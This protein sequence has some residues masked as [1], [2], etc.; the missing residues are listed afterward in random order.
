MRIS[1][2]FSCD[3]GFGYASAGIRSQSNVMATLHDH[4][5]LLF[6]C[7]PKLNEGWGWP[8]ITHNVTSFFFFFFFLSV[9]RP[10]TRSKKKNC[11]TKRTRM[12]L[13]CSP[14]LRGP[15][16]FAPDMARSRGYRGV[17]GSSIQS[18]PGERVRAAQE[19]QG[20]SKPS[21]FPEHSGRPVEKKCG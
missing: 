17:G 11:Q 2:Y 13:L 1:T 8:C 10:A 6:S 14:R 12:K 15:F 7:Q 16:H 21:R 9:R 20:P 4:E 5:V 19:V 3:V 18:P